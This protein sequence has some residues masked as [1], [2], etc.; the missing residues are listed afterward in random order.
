MFECGVSPCKEC[1]NGP[2][3]QQCRFTSKFQGWWKD[4]WNWNWKVTQL[5]GR[6]W[7]SPDKH[8][9]D[10][11]RKNMQSTGPLHTA[12]NPKTSAGQSSTNGPGIMR[13]QFCWSHWCSKLIYP[14]NNL[15]VASFGKASRPTL[16]YPISK[17]TYFL[18]SIFRH[19]HPSIFHF[20]LSSCVRSATFVGWQLRSCQRAATR[21]GTRGG[22]VV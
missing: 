6:L 19:F 8:S 3:Q 17:C 13:Q 10:D 15:R 16:G 12:T 18:P 9:T 1:K 5:L 11:V 2:Y 21:K 14:W 22:L 20:T 4:H 7:T